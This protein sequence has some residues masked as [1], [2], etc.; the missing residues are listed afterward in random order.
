MD[1]KVSEK[2]AG[3]VSSKCI[4]VNI[5]KCNRKPVMSNIPQGVNTGTNTI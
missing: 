1:Y 5:P 2:Q 3:Q 4:E